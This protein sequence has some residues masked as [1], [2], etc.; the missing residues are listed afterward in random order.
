MAG[1]EQRDGVV[2]GDGQGE[3]GAV[4]RPSRRGQD[5]EHRERQQ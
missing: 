1:H 2:V 3:G 4:E 5:R